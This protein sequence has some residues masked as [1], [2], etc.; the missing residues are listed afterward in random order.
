MKWA[1][2]QNGFTIVELLIVVVVIAILAA[3]TIVAYTGIQ[4]RAYDATIKS[5]LKNAAV[6]L[7]SYKAL[8]GN[9]P[10]NAGQ[11]TSLND[12]R[13]IAI[14]KSAYSLNLNNN[15]AL[16]SK[17]DAFGIAGQ[18]KSGKSF[19]YT[20]S[21]G[22]YEYTSDWSASLSTNCTTLINDSSP[23]YFNWGYTSLTWQAWLAP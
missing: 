10:V 23:S 18:S 15:V 2:K 7:E 21:K 17:S 11:V 3:I 4:T 16:C 9:F 1:Q 5:D 14:T 6:A 13:R 12:G 22:L 8:Q 20:S 19:A